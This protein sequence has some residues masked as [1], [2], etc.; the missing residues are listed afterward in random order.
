M[1][2]SFWASLSGT[3]FSITA[4]A[5]LEHP[6]LPEAT[7]DWLLVSAHAL[8][9]SLLGI[10]LIISLSL[11]TPL[12]VSLLKQLYLVCMFILQETLMKGMVKKETSIL[13]I[14]G[15]TYRLFLSIFI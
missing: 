6:V 9:S 1:T 15:K 12:V 7:I 5:V 10:V 3:L 8:S 4:S 14:P 2:Q 11:L 13:E